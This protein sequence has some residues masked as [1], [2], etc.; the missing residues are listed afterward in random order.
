MSKSICNF[1]AVYFNSQLVL[2]VLSCE[3]RHRQKVIKSRGICWW[4]LEVEEEILWIYFR[5]LC[6][7]I[8]EVE[9]GILWIYSESNEL[10]KELQNSCNIWEILPI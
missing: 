5:G 4:I 9:E 2:L 8:M 1:T 10:K 3:P 7:W 6:W